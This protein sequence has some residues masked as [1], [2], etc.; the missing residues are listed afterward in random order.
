MKG[1]ET[2]LGRRGPVPLQR[3]YFRKVKYFLKR[4]LRFVMPPE[5]SP[6]LLFSELRIR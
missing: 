4:Y 6:S 1:E 5:T 3:K 2:A